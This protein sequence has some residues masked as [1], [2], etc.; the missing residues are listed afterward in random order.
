MDRLAKEELD[1]T[2][3][4]VRDEDRVRGYSDYDPSEARAAHEL[5]VPFNIALALSEIGLLK[6]P[7]GPTDARRKVLD[8]VVSRLQD[9]QPKRRR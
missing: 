5:Q 1:R 9:G 7:P 6:D 4:L 3:D 2:L 8:D